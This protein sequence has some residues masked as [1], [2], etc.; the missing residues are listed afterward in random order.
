VV[1]QNQMKL[2]ITKLSSHNKIFHS[3]TVNN[4]NNNSISSIKASKSKHNN[5]H[6]PS[7]NNLF[8]QKLTS[9]KQKASLKKFKFGDKMNIYKKKNESQH[10]INSVG[11]KFPIDQLSKTNSQYINYKYLKNNNST[12]YSFNNNKKINNSHLKNTFNINKSQNFNNK[13]SKTTKSINSSN[14]NNYINNSAFYANNNKNKSKNSISNSN[15]INTNNYIINTLNVSEKNF[16]R[17]GIS[18]AKPQKSSQK[19]NKDYEGEINKLIREKEECEST[20][21]KQEKLIEKLKEDNDKLDNKI[22][23]ILNENK[24][25][26]KKIELHQENQEQLIMLI[27]IVQRSGVDVEKLI[28]KWNNDVEME[29][30]NISSDSNYNNTESY[31]DSMNELNSKIDPSSFIP[32]NI[33]EPH[34]NKKV[35]KGIP[36]LNFDIIKNGDENNRKGKYRNHS[37]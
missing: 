32:I 20:I 9:F 14:I 17:T 15:S 33:E 12:K 31:T 30:N 27:K 26:S 29:N 35:L 37:K 16:M 25:I 34:I 36:K 7:K 3:S 1:K 18:S 13:I 21:K 6:P 24:K 10:H 4:T 8:N 11:S 5:F 19:L 28:D 23:Y 2:S 22:S